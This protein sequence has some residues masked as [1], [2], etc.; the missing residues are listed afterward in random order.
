MLLKLQP[1]AGRDLLAL[2]SNRLTG[3]GLHH[4]VSDADSEVVVGLEKPLSSEVLTDLQALGCIA[5]MIPISTPWKLASKAFKK[6]KTQIRIKGVT[7]G[8]PEV[9]MMAG[10]CAIESEEQLRS[11]AQQLAKAKVRSFAVPLS[12]RE[13]LPTAS[14]GWASRACAFTKCSKKSTAC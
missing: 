7:I 4:C 9:V 1:N 2:L 10:P 3:L 8:G 12:S 13:P 14:K 6:E 5:E 11:I